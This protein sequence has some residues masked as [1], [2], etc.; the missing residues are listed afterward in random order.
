M[1]RKPFCIDIAMKLIAKAVEPLPKAGLF[2]LAEEGFNSPF[3]LLVACIISI[4]T[5]DEVM[6]RIAREFFAHAGTPQE[7]SHLSITEID[8]LIGACTF[9]E[10]KATQIFEISKKIMTEYNGN[11]PA[12]LE[13][14]LSFK[15]VGPKCANLV[16]AIT[17]G[18]AKIGVDTHVHRI[19]NRW[20]YVKTS[21]P[22]KTLAALEKKLPKEYW[23]EI[24]RILVP[25]GK[26]ICGA[27][28]PKCSHCP[29]KDMCPKIGVEPNLYL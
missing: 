26:H 10:R 7:V 28:K 5:L 1:S 3:Q 29:I 2:E 12:K 9:H 23:I 16:M 21:N 25:F 6:L 27:N 22:E 19:T 13:I 17:T 20:D 8:R 15:G 24:N 11:L 4:Q 18:E 14:L